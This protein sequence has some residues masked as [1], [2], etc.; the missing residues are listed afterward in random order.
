MH[1]N[2]LKNYS[3]LTAQKRKIRTCTHAST[4]KQLKV[5]S[6]LLV[7]PVSPVTVNKAVL[8]HIIQGLHPFST[9][10]LQSF[11][12]LIST[13]QPDSSVITWP[14]LRSKIAEAALIM[15][16]KLTAA[17]SRVEWII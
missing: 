15:K 14:T 5:D 6:V 7:K 4:S 16:Q 13:L 1:P 17:M 3:I 11:K 2:Y 9:V 10:D 12:E 8:R